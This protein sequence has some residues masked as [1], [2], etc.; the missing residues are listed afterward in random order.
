MA[1]SDPRGHNGR[2]EYDPDGHAMP[3][4]RVP[5][6]PWMVAV[7]MVAALALGGV[8]FWQLNANRLRVAETRMTDPTTDSAPI[9]SSAEAPEPGDIIPISDG[10]AETE[11]PPSMAGATPPTVS[12]LTAPPA[13][14]SAA[15]IEAQARQKAPALI[16]DLS[17]GQTNN[18]APTLGQTPLTPGQVAGLSASARAKDGMNEDERF[19][20]RLGA[21]GVDAA[22]ASRIGDPA[23]TV[24]QGAV[25][26]AVLETAINSD[27]PG[28]TRALVSRDVKGFDG[29]KVLIPRGSRL[30]GQY[31]SGVALGHSRAFVIWTRLVR[32][33]GVTIQ[34]ASPG[35]DALGRGGLEGKVDRHFLRRFGGSILLSLVTAGVNA[36][37]DDSDTQVI[38][39]SSRG[40]G[41]A[42]SVALAKEIDQPPTIR[43]PQGAPIRIFVARD[44]DFSTAQ[45]AP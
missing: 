41:D 22:R 19:A 40:A 42:A 25:I 15:Q 11:P 16:I 27:L 23:Q 7:W 43:V 31:R 9:I 37:A 38:I 20:E 36:A 32:P 34:L 45:G 14:A 2:P 5:Q 35:A 21:D 26:P 30:I 1:M 3:R 10:F 29:T 28:F 17:D 13:S 39:A 6:R 33:D 12:A 24:L 4:V 44:L 18:T 8:V